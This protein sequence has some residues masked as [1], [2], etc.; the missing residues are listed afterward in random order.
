MSNS[1]SSYYSPCLQSIFLLSC[2]IYI[3]DKNTNHILYTHPRKQ[4]ACKHPTP[5]ASCF[6]FHAFITKLLHD[7]IIVYVVHAFV[8]LCGHI[9]TCMCTLTNTSFPL[10]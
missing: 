8:R 2:A 6:Q 5:L 1:L 9:V 7:I 3:H 10:R 4:N